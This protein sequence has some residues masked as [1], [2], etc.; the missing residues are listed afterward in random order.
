MRKTMPH[1]R[2]PARAVLRPAN[3]SPRCHM[4]C[5]DLQ[6]EGGYAWHMQLEAWRLSHAV[7]RRQAA[8]STMLGVHDLNAHVCL[9]MLAPF[10]PL[11]PAPTLDPPN[12]T[13]RQKFNADECPCEQLQAMRAGHGTLV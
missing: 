1:F 12:T 9:D 8:G 10:T 3:L 11:G 4:R 7:G 13:Q 5:W 2:A 6:G